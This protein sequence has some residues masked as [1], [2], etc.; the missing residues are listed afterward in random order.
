MTISNEIASITILVP[1]NKGDET[2]NQII[3]FKVYRD[4]QRFKAIP[5]ITEEERIL[6]GLPAEILFQFV[7]YT[8]IP[9]AETNEENLESINNIVRELKMLRIV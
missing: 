9:A 7:N 5:L 4:Q 8:V 1:Y 3:P 6:T 2:I